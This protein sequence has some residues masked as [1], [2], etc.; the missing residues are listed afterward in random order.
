[1]DRVDSVKKLSK[2]GKGYIFLIAVSV[3]VILII[4]DFEI[5]DKIQ[6]DLTTVI[7]LILIVSFF[8]VSFF[9]CIN[10]FTNNLKRKRIGKNK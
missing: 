1:M 10:R 2:M 5:V 6:Q 3:V 9:G 7:G 4:S 8:V